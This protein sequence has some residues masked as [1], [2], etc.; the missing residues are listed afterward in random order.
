VYSNIYFQT[1]SLPIFAPL[2]NL[3]NLSGK[4]VIPL[5][6]ADLLTPIGLSYWIC[7][8]GSR[9]KQDRYVV[10]CTECFTLEEVYLLLEVLN[11]K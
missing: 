3:F 6:I 1:Y 5:N 11:N 9:N 2:Y 4:K 10:L 8:D 7:D